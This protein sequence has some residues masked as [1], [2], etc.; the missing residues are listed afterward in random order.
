MSPDQYH[1]NKA[2]TM[3]SSPKYS[4][5][6]KRPQGQNFEDDEFCNMEQGRYESTS[7]V[8]T[9]QFKSANQPRPNSTLAPRGR[10]KNM[11]NSTAKKQPFAYEL[12]SYNEPQKFGNSAKGLQ[13]GAP[14]REQR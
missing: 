11:K 8:A 12:D 5:G 3:Y 4:I 2:S 6:Q 14:K 13:F 7:K 9:H 10:T 1:P